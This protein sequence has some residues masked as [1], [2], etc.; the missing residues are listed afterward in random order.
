MFLSLSSLPRVCVRW[1]YLLLGEEAS[2]LDLG[3]PVEAD[4][5]DL[6]AGVLLG[7]LVDLLEDGGGVGAAEHGELPHEPVPVVVEAGAA[8][9]GLLDEGLVLTDG[10]LDAGR[11]AVVEKVLDLSGGLLG[12]ELG[13]V[14]KV[15]VP[16]LGLEGLLSTS[17]AEKEGGGGGETRQHVVFARKKE[18]KKQDPAIVILKVGGC[19]ARAN[20]RTCGVRTW[21]TPRRA[22][23]EQGR[24]ARA[25]SHLTC[26][27]HTLEP[28]L[29]APTRAERLELAR[30]TA[31]AFLVSEA[32]SIMA[33]L[34]V[35]CWVL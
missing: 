6:G 32:E 1:S 35:W 18:R 10:E 17:E 21:R 30:L 13:K 25:C 2:L 12:G 19:G 4:H 34:R 9:E 8:L 27:M 20:V 11:P 31:T 16:P 23:Q 7:A 5:A 24:V 28:F 14:G 15:L 26:I 3:D 22:C 29:T 33:A